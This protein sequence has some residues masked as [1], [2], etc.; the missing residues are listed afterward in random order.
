MLWA[1]KFFLK[2][3]LI[4]LKYVFINLITFFINSY[5]IPRSEEKVI[6]E[7][8]KSFIAERFQDVAMVDL[9]SRFGDDTSP[10]F[11]VNQS[12]RLPDVTPF[13]GVPRDAPFSLWVPKHSKIAGQLVQLFMDQRTVDDLVSTAAYI[14]DRI[15]PQLFNYA[16]SVVLLHRKDTKGVDIPAFVETF[17][18][19]FVD[20]RVIRQAREDISVVPQGSRNPIVIPVDFTASD[21][22]PEHK[23]WYFREDLGINLHHWHWH[24]VCVHKTFPCVN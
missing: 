12:S 6:F 2:S 14:R 1:P 11:S 13:K 9:T 16:L 24:L 3:I 7:I 8:P 20:P 4:V 23:L 10:R 22:D 21:L 17:P 5:F 18:D 19:K 15:N